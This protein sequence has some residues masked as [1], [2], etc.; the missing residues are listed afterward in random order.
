MSHLRVNVRMLNRYSMQNNKKT[1]FLSRH[2]LRY[3]SNSDTYI[4]GYVDVN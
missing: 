3:L 1:I 4:F 2:Y